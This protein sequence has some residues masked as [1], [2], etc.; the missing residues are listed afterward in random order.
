MESNKAEYIEAVEGWLPR[1]WE[2]GDAGQRV[3]SC[4]NVG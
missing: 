1:V 4:N 2:W 3:Q